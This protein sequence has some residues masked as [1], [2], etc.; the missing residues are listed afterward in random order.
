MKQAILIAMKH[1]RISILFMVMLVQNTVQAQYFEVN[2]I[3]ISGNIDIAAQDFCGA[4]LESGSQAIFPIMPNF[5]GSDFGTYNFLNKTSHGFCNCDNGGSHSGS[6]S[7]SRFFL[8]G[9]GENVMSIRWKNTGSQYATTDA[10]YFSIT[11]DT[12]SFDVNFGI[13]GVI[14]GTTVNIYYQYT[15]FAG[16]TTYHFPDYG[17]VNEDSVRV[18]NSMFINGTEQLNNAFSWIPPQDGWN[19]KTEY[20]MFTLL[21][22]NSSN[23]SISSIIDLY[24]SDP[25]QPGGYGCPIDENS[26]IIHGNIVFSLTPLYN[27][28]NPGSFGQNEQ[29]LFS[30]DIGSDSEYSDFQINGN[31]NFDPGDMYARSTSSSVSNNGIFD[32]SDF[33]AHDPVP[34]ILNTLIPYHSG[35]DIQSISPSIFDLDGFDATDFSLHNLSLAG[36]NFPIDGWDSNQTYKAENFLISLEDDSPFNYT[37]VM[38]AVPIES[39]SSSGRIYGADQY[40]DEIFMLNADPLLPGLTSLT[41]VLPEDQ[42]H[43]ALAPNPLAEFLDD[44]L[45]ALDLV[46]M[47]PSG[48]ISQTFRYFGADHEAAYNHPGSG[49]P[50]LN[51]SSIYEMISPGMIAE[52]V[53]FQDLGIPVGTDLADFEFGFAPWIGGF[54]G[55]RLAVFFSV[56]PDDPNTP[57]DESGSLNPGLIYY[58]FMSGFHLAWTSIP[59]SAPI[60]GIALASHLQIPDFI[61]CQQMF[62]RD[63]DGDGY[64]NLHFP[65][66]ACNAPLM[67]VTNHLDCDDL[68]PT[69]HPGA[70][71]TQQG[72]DNNCDGVIDPSEV[73][74][75]P[76]DLNGD[77][78]VNTTD[79]LIFLGSYGCVGT[80]GAADI[81]GDGYVNSTD[82]LILLGKYG[83]NCP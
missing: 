59:L 7:G 4:P 58:S 54:A 60:D 23:F 62:Y 78:Q 76:E 34:N 25:G 9:D 26:G 70:P 17:E 22:G 27:P 42:V 41:P 47:D 77:G 21:V 80:C 63:E 5:L 11:H 64:G 40:R 19:A 1:Q 79:L 37:S 43:K 71:G 20:G 38:P 72:I 83:T 50:L 57:D 46:S 14:P 66:M 55:D 12:L 13:V 3:N 8:D 68:D 82:L 53:D 67:H 18:A 45:D 15:V 36:I 49:F 2:A 52:V 35:M 65:A 56:H 32:D 6:I 10:G 28:D 81:N 61:T 69:V 33:F 44:D 39:S 51:S 75:C 74:S 30:L 29:L 48:Q 73:S 24:M 31:E 16:A